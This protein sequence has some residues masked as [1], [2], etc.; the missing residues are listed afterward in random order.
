MLAVWTLNV[1]GRREFWEKMSTKVSVEYVKIPKLS[2]RHEPAALSLSIL[3]GFD[4]GRS[5]YSSN[6]MDFFIDFILAESS[7]AF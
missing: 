2:L 1:A 7:I 5:D 6:Y 4:Q 3:A